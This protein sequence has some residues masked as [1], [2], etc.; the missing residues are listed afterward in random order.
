MRFIDSIALRRID[1]RGIKEEAKRPT[2]RLLHCSRMFRKVR[3][4]WI[5]QVAA[6]TERRGS[7]QDIFW[8]Q[9]YQGLL[10]NGMEEIREREESRLYESGFSRKTEQMRYI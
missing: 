10:I 8:R 9:N 2:G 3:V 6:E 1:L 7:I 5:G 4:A